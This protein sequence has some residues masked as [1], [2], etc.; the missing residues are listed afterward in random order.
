MLYLTYT[1]ERQSRVLPG[2]DARKQLD[3]LRRH[4]D[5]REVPLPKNW[6]NFIS[7]PGNKVDLAN[8]V[9]KHRMIVVA[10]GFT[11]ELEARSSKT[12]TNEEA[13]TRLLLHAVHSQFNTVVVSSRDTDVLV[14]LVANFPSV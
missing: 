12:T 11:E 7:F 5:G 6:I 4:I 8:C 10:A 14:L 1:E 2:R 3:Q 13:D 9:V